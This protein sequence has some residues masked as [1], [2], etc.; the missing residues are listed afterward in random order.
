MTHAHTHT[1]NGKRMGRKFGGVKNEPMQ[2][3]CA[4]LC[5][6]SRATSTTNELGTLGGVRPRCVLQF[7]RKAI[8]DQERAH[9]LSKGTLVFDVELG[10]LAIGEVGD[11]GR[12]LGAKS[13]QFLGR[14]GAIHIVDQRESD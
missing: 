13:A 4:S 11:L 3:L 9:L 5:K 2:G 1:H 7:S 8:F 14:G 10:F 12:N 6:M